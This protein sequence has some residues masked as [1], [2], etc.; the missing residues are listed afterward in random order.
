MPNRA[1]GFRLPIVGREEKREVLFSRGL[2]DLGSLP[3]GQSATVRYEIAWTCAKT[4]VVEN[5]RL[6]RMGADFNKSMGDQL[7]E[8]VTEI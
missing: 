6:L 2:T 1:I 4:V 3:R 7:A 8:P 5:A